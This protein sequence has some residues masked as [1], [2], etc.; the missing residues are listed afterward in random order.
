MTIRG[1]TGVK[2][3]VRSV[4]QNGPASPRS[5]YLSDRLSSNMSNVSPS[6]TSFRCA[7]DVESAMY[8]CDVQQMVGDLQQQ[9]QKGAPGARRE[10]AWSLAA[11]REVV[12]SPAVAPDS[13]LVVVQ[14]QSPDVAAAVAAAVAA[15]R[16]LEWQ[17][18]QLPNCRGGPCRQRPAWHAPYQRPV[19]RNSNTSL[20]LFNSSVRQHRAHE[21]S[22]RN[23]VLFQGATCLCPVS[24]VV[25]SKS[26][27]AICIIYPAVC[28]MLDASRFQVLQREVHRASL[29][30]GQVFGRPTV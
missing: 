8:T 29:G 12:L 11:D 24:D 17:R 28:Y 3:G 2:E 23:A 22:S 13:I 30:Q 26:Y 9:L 18:Q 6:L 1:V 19:S 14:Q 25:S 7:D 15:E 16:W 27:R 21:L 5:S 10:A 4:N 20:H